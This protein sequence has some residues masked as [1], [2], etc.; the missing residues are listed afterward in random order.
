MSSAELFL[1]FLVALIVFGP[2]KLPMLAEHL[3]KLFRL[4][5]QFKQQATTFWE[6]QLSEYQLKENTRKA[7]QADTL[8]QKIEQQND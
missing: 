1:T 3:G 5:N 8:Y 4:L 7:E 6:T 2:N